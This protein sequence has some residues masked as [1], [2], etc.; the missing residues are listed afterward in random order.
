MERDVL[1]ELLKEACGSRGEGDFAVSERDVVT[2]LV[3][4][5]GTWYPVEGVRQ[6]GLK[7]GF[8]TL[9]TEEGENHLVGME[10]VVGVRI[11]RAKREGAGFR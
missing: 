5:H 11:R 1:R 10:H 8:V 2:V 3:A 9:E 4:A 7:A 6:V